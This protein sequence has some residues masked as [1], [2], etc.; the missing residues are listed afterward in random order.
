MGDQY[1]TF[2]A[3]VIDLLIQPIDDITE[4]VLK[5]DRQT[6][7][8]GTVPDPRIGCFCP[9]G[10]GFAC[11]TDPDTQHLD[12]GYLHIAILAGGMKGDTWGFMNEAQQLAV[13]GQVLQEVLGESAIDQ[14]TAALLREVPL[15]RKD[16][17]RIFLVSENGSHE[18]RH[19][20]TW[21]VMK[22]KTAGG[23]P[24][25]RINFVRDASTRKFPGEASIAL[26]M[27]AQLTCFARNASLGKESVRS[28]GVDTSERPPYAPSSVTDSPR[29]FISQQKE[30]DAG[31]A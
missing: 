21:T 19:V 8:Q 13:R 22:P 10:V 30:T 14:A 11:V 27:S 24:D 4:I 28:D 23:V 31:A 16:G 5:G 17:D 29:D 18:D 6:F 15:I 1:G 2:S 26:R 25:V 3:C 9:M 20:A 7:R 12:G